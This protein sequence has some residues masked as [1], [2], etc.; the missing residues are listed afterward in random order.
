MRI[1]KISTYHLVIELMYEGKAEIIPEIKGLEPFDVKE[2]LQA[3]RKRS[4]EDF[5]D[6]YDRWSNWFLETE[7]VASKYEKN[8]LEH[9]REFKKKN[10][11]YVDKLSGHKKEI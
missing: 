10:D 11:Y 6:T 9:L 2:I 8:T 5:G 7:D 3:L 1:D 4:G